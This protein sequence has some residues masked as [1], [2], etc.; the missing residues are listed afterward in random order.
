MFYQT[1]AAKNVATPNDGHMFTAGAQIALQAEEL[2]QK[3][4]MLEHQKQQLIEAKMG[5]FAEAVEKGQQYTGKA[6]TNYYNKFLPQYRTA[7]GLQDMISDDALQFNGASEEMIRRQGS[8]IS[9]VNRREITMEKAL[10]IYHDPQK[11]ADMFGGSPDVMNSAPL[12]RTFS[13]ELDKAE[14]AAEINRAAMTKQAIDI[15]SKGDVAVA[16]KLG[17]DYANFTAGNGQSGATAKLK[18]LDAVIKGLESGKI[19]TGT[20]TGSIPGLKS[21]VVQAVVN[22]A[23]KNAMDDVQGAISLKS[24]LDSQFSAQEAELVLS[25]SFDPAL[26]TKDNLRKVRALRDELRGDLAN[27]MTEFGKQGFLK[28]AK[29]GKSTAPVVPA[30]APADAGATAPEPGEQITPPGRRNLHE[31]EDATKRAEILQSIKTA[32]GID[33]NLVKKAASLYGT[34]VNQLKAALGIQ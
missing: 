5:K 1:A 34:S 29:G 6:Q 19:Q 26:S 24:S 30:A 22:P 16:Q 32:V 33:E 17:A 25:R 11:M 12:D 13:A 18:K 10:E 4:Q 15:N 14:K 21:G 9:K 28:G 31:I 7:I 20:L 27:K 2:Q 23:L 8:L 3:R